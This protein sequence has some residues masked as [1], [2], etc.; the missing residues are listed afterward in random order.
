MSGSIVLKEKSRLQSSTSQA[1]TTGLTAASIESAASG[2][3]TVNGSVNICSGP[4]CWAQHKEHRNFFQEAAARAPWMYAVIR[5]CFLCNWGGDSI[6]QSLETLQSRSITPFE[7]NLFRVRLLMSSKTC[8]GWSEFM[9]PTYPNFEKFSRWQSHI[10]AN[11]GDCLW[12]S[13]R[14]GSWR[15]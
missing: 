8:I 11:N 15:F 14:N 10:Q 5:A 3:V 12:R 2:S 7:Y 4:C 1:P 6:F 9:M 13:E